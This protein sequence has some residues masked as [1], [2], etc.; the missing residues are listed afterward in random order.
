MDPVTVTLGVAAAALVVKA[1]EKAGEKLVDA[2][3]ASLDRLVGWLRGRFTQSDGTTDAEALANVEAVPDSP[4]RVQ[5]LAE[6]IDKRSAE[7]PMFRTELEALLEQVR[8]A[9]VHVA[10]VLQSAVGNQNV[11]V[12]H[13]KGSTV[14]IS[15]GSSIPPNI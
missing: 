11:Q 7:D 10:P 12:A 2:S 15:Y 6:A 13:V 9:G 14:S 1:A 5:A 8:D 4:S 3:T